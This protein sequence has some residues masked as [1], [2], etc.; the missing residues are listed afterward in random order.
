MTFVPFSGLCAP[1]DAACKAPTPL[2]TS[3]GCSPQR[4]SAARLL[5]PVALAAAALFGMAAA[6]AQTATPTNPTE[7][8]GNARPEARVQRIT[9]EDAGSRI[10]ELR[11][12]G[13]TRQIDVQTRSGLPGYQVQPSAGPSGTATPASERSGSHG[14]AGRSSWRLVDF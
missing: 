9:H 5:V 2:S 13:M 4:P 3:G 12:G 1:S 7:A 11:V 14:S 10:D 6:G 8:T